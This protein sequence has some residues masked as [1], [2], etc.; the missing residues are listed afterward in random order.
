MLKDTLIADVD[1]FPVKPLVAA[2]YNWVIRHHLQ[3]ALEGQLAA[4]DAMVKL[5][6]AVHH[7]DIQAWLGIAGEEDARKIIGMLFT[8]IST[9]PYLGARRLLVYGLNL[10][11]QIAPE[12][13]SK[14][15]N[16]LAEYA[17]KRGC[18]TMIA[19]TKVKG[20]GRLLERNGWTNGMSIL[21][22]EL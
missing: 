18:H 7:G 9:D 12:A 19:Q 4:P 6:K 14:C 20:L 22:K 21:T 16:T 11:A 10:E 1:L 15:M 8:S 17:R 3:K 2:K 5:I 13:F